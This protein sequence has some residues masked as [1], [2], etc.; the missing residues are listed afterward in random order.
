MAAFTAK[1]M[2][3]RIFAQRFFRFPEPRLL[4]PSAQS[5]AR[6]PEYS[7]DRTL[8]AQMAADGNSNC[9]DEVLQPDIHTC[10]IRRRSGHRVAGRLPA[11]EG[12]VRR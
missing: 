11:T 3:A 1:A 8:I 9:D 5:T 10:R 4:R 2:E 6:N 12:L 7:A